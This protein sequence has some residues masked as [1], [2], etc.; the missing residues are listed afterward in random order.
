MTTTD[1]KEGEAEF[2]SVLYFMIG[3]EMYWIIARLG[4]MAPLVIL[5]WPDMSG[6][7]TRLKGFVRPMIYSISTSSY[8]LSKSPF[9]S[10]M[11][12]LRPNA[13]IL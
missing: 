6:F 7:D 13:P 9:F 8:I 1:V 5:P 3:H 12:F 11:C 4:A 10:T 2:Y